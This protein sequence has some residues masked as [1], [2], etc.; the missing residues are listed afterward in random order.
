M[1]F[2]EDAGIVAIA[3]GSDTE[4]HAA[5]V[6]ILNEMKYLRSLAGAISLGPDLADIK[7]NI[8]RTDQA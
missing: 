5:F 1:S 6:R 2:Q 4:A 7:K 8:R 3:L